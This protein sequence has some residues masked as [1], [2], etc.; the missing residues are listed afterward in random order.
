M[1]LLDLFLV[2]DVLGYYGH[3]CTTVGFQT[4]GRRTGADYSGT[5]SV[6]SD[7]RVACSKPGPQPRRY[8]AHPLYVLRRSTAH[9]SLERSS[10]M[11][12]MSSSAGTALNACHLFP[13][14]TS[15]LNLMNS[16]NLSDSEG[17]RPRRAHRVYWLQRRRVRVRRVGDM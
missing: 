11:N 4:V 10:A 13:V 14:C 2:H 9:G 7:H 12:S 16:L 17:C 5:S 1:A 3:P 8:A 6:C 15:C